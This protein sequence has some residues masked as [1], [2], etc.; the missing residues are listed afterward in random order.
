[1][2]FLIG[3]PFVYHLVRRD[4]PIRREVYDENHAAVRIAV[5]IERYVGEPHTFEFD[6][7]GMGRGIP[8]S[9]GENF[10][11]RFRPILPGGALGCRLRS[12]T[13]H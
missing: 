8:K 1:M 3:L 5:V 4:E 2:P 10:L 13:S 6:F 12:L 11:R 7:P 9:V